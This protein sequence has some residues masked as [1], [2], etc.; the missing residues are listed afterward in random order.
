ME[1]GTGDQGG[2]QPAALALE[3]L[4]GLNANRKKNERLSCGQKI[5]R[6]TKKAQEYSLRKSKQGLMARFF[7]SCAASYSY[8]GYYTKRTVCPE[9]PLKPMVFVAY[10]RNIDFKI[11]YSITRILLNI[12]NIT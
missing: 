5:V 10:R 7:I 8:R 6:L 11:V 3:G 12:N 9:T 1:Q 2:L 4:R